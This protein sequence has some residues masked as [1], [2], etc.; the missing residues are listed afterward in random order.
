MFC[1]VLII[2]PVISTTASADA[3]PTISSKK[4]EKQLHIYIGMINYYHDMWQNCSKVLAS[5]VVLMPNT[6]PWKWV[7]V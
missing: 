3:N 5:L 2:T 4:E 7:S 1:V 6:A